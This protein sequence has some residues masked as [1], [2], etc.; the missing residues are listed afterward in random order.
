MVAGRNAA[1]STIQLKQFMSYN[2]APNRRHDEKWA[3]GINALKAFLKSQEVI[4]QAIGGRNR[5]GESVTGTR[6]VEFE[7]HHIK[8]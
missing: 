8:H 6:Q 2:N 7:Q 3:I 1:D 5:K 4:V